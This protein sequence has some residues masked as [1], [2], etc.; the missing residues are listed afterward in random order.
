MAGFSALAVL[1]AGMPFVRGATRA[2]DLAFGIA[3][4]AFGAIGAMLA[5]RALAIG[6]V[7]VAS[8]IFSI[9]G[10]AL[11][12]LVG[13]VLGDR[14]SAL[15]LVGLGLAPISIVAL[16]QGGHPG[17]GDPR[18]AVVP[19][20]V[21]GAVLGFFLVFYGRIGR[22]SSL[23]PLIAARVAGIA[24]LAVVL[25]ARRRPLLPASADRGMALLVGGLDSCANLAYVA[26]VQR[27]SLALVA[28]LV[29]LAPATSVL[30]ARAFLG[31]RWTSWQLTGLALALSAGVCISFG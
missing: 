10:L 12:V 11:P 9:T 2:N 28:A 30:L 21:A 23:W 5:Y 1:F 22:G 29:S 19:S 31:E 7:T 14:P 20:L 26:A 16:A 27:G 24:C 4:G 6:P 8:P 18:R 3:G 17:G 25:L 13:V 15:A